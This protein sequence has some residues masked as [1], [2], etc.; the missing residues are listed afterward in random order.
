LIVVVDKFTKCIEA[1]PLAKIGF[2]QAVDFIQDI[3]FCFG[4]LTLSLPTMALTSPE[5]G[6][7]ISATIITSAWTGLRS[8]THVQM[9]KSSE[10][11]T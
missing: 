6:S 1:K 4:S 10:L 11:T 3:I 8:P 2:K 5:K 7:G 9:G